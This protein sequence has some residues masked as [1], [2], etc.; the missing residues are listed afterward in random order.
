[1]RRLLGLGAV[2]VV[3]LGGGSA[4]ATAPYCA[5]YSDGGVNCGFYTRWSCRAAVSGVGGTCH[6]NPAGRYVHAERVARPRGKT[7][8]RAEP[9][10]YSPHCRAYLGFLWWVPCEP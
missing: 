3:V 9:L 10:R 6:V 1:M 7:A 8:R 4:Q 5:V 2:A